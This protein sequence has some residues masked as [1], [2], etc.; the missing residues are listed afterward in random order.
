VSS[1]AQSPNFIVTVNGIKSAYLTSLT[2][3]FVDV[4]HVTLLTLT[5]SVLN[6]GLDNTNS[7]ITDLTVVSVKFDEQIC[8]INANST[9]ITN[10]NCQL[11][12]NTDNTDNTPIIRAGVITP[13]IYVTSLGY[14]SLNTTPPITVPLVLTALSITTGG[15]NGGYLVNLTGKGFPL[16]ASQVTINVCNKSATINSINNIK[17][18]FFMP[19][20]STLGLQ[21][22]TFQYNSEN[23]TT[24]SFTYTNALTVSPI[25]TTITPNSANPTIKSTINI[26]GQR[27]GADINAVTIFLS[28]STGRIYQLRI[29]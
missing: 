11:P 9:L 13:E 28:N 21:T 6:I 24:L 7:L 22:L 4:S 14:I 2:Y 3:T 25:I 12:I 10:F 23:Y 5:G 16:L 8:V 29:I 15:N 27:F 18:L 20:C 26:V 17:I 1:S 19:S